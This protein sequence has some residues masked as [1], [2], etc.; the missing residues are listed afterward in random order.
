L[1][2]VLRQRHAPPEQV[3]H[4]RHADDTA[5]AF[6]ERRPGHACYG[7]QLGDRPSAEHIPMNSR[8]GHSDPGVGQTGEQR[9]TSGNGPGGC[10]SQRLDEHDL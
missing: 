7:R 5:E 8:Q 3:V 4:R 6:G 1:E 10:M 9:L 2:R